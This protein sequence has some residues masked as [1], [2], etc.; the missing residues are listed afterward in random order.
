V[1]N[2][3]A[4]RNNSEKKWQRLLI[5]LWLAIYIPSY[6]RY[7]GAWHFLQLCNLSIL[8]GSVGLFSR[9]Q[10]IISS[11]ALAMSVIALIW[12]LDA[13]SYLFNGKFIHHGTAY[14]WDTNIPLFIRL[15][16]FYHIIWPALMCYYTW[17]RG[18]DSRALALQGT[19]A[20]V[21]MAF[22]LFLTPTAEN[23]N[24]VFHWP[25]G[26]LLFSN[27]ALHTCASFSGLVVFIYL[28]THFIL[29]LMPRK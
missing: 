22:G 2:N 19:V 1:D 4:A 11:Q 12:L 16:S 7:Y 3:L 27:P 14:M 20:A 5:L 25:N 26:T 28:P 6:A 23:I 8:L 13:S 18:Y 9:N 21:A 17:V 10:L 24:Y 29:K 15:L